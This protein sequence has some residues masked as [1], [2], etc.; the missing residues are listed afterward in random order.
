MDSNNIIN[1]SNKRHLHSFSISNSPIKQKQLTRNILT[2][3]LSINNSSFRR[4]KTFN[5]FLQN[6]LPIK[7][8]KKF[9]DN[10]QPKFIKKPLTLLDNFYKHY[11]IINI[12][13]N[14]LKKDMKRNLIKYKNEA[15]K[16]KRENYR[17]FSD[18]KNKKYNYKNNINL[19]RKKSNNNKSKEEIIIKNLKT[20]TEKK[21]R[22]FP[23]KKNRFQN[24]F[25]KL[26]KE[27]HE[28]YM[29]NTPLSEILLVKKS[30]NEYKQKFIIN[31][32][33]VLIDNLNYFHNT[34]LCINTLLFKAI[35]NLNTKEQINY[36]KLIENLCSMLV[37]IPKIIL[38]NFYDSMEQYYYCDIPFLEDYSSLK[39]DSEYDCTISNLELLKMVIVY[40]RTTQEVYE[41]I[42]KKTDKLDM[43]EN[44]FQ[45]VLVY[46]DMSRFKSSK[47][48]IR[49]KSLIEK[50]KDDKS[51]LNLLYNKNE[52]HLK[53][54]N[55]MGSQLKEEFNQKLFRVNKAINYKRD[56]YDIDFQEK[57]EKI[58]RKQ[59]TT[60]NSMLHSGVL[61]N[62]LKYVGP[63]A[64]EKIIKMR[65]IDKFEH[66]NHNYEGNI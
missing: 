57:K 59:L 34:Y 36:N 47:L 39:F 50:L 63:N 13:T 20:Q 46:I 15:M 12:Q 3:N 48:N 4:Q 61:S 10:Y 44:D 38:G 17:T 18:D 65:V 31:R 23:R 35:Q 19:F 9:P 32:L 43:T 37:E 42:V 16:L 49:T 1:N 27:H 51:F 5:N 2:E 56:N 64:K 22:Y 54:S 58:K 21:E 41:N 14:F 29:K 60:M 45:T 26:K 55:S 28:Y 30:T 33:K 40:I 7:L 62:L 11:Q 8:I 6:N 52:K 25:E 66:M 24:D 53:F